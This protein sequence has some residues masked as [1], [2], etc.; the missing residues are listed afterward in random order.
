MNIYWKK[1]QE[2]V[3]KKIS[4]H[5]KFIAEFIENLSGEKLEVVDFDRLIINLN[6]VSNLA[7]SIERVQSELVLLRNDYIGR[8]SG[9]AK[10]VA[11]A[12]HR[13]DDMEE[14]LEFVNTL[15][16]SSSE[17]LLKAYRKIQSKFQD[18]F[19]ASFG[20]LNR[21]YQTVNDKVLKDLN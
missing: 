10:A 17:K 3:F 2:S 18:S 5:K 14:L 9:M 21:K 15:D 4:D 11:V 12:S 19:P 13:R 16:N 8:I 6:E 20:L 7:S 1:R